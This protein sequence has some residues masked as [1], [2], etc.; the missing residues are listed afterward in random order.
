MSGFIFSIFKKITKHLLA[1]SKKK[2]QLL[3]KLRFLAQVTLWE[4]KITLGQ[5]VYFLHPVKFQGYGALIVEEN[6]TFGYELANAQSIPILLQPRK[7]NAII[8]ISAGSHIVNGTEI[9][10]Q[11]CVI[12]GKNCQIGA[13]TL[14][15]DSDFHGIAPEKRKSEGKISPVIIKDNVWTGTDVTI[16][17]G[18]TI[19][20]DAVLGARSVISKNVPP[21]AIVVGNPMRVV[22]SVYDQ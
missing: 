4:G 7:V 5:S 16:L 22:G 8:K 21:G 19:G 20:Q 6:V 13:R 12:I 15:M 3:Y 9:I 10:A 17:K 2:L 1:F 14:I 11:Q 18:V